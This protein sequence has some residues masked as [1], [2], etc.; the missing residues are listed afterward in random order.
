LVAVLTNATDNTQ[1]IRAEEA[2][3]RER[4][5][6]LAAAE[7]REAPDGPWDWAKLRGLAQHFLLLMKGRS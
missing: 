6:S 3:E 7:A 5:R 4:A 1:A 2:A